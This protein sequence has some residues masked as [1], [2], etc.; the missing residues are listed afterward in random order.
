MPANPL[1]FG[2][3]G[4]GAWGRCH[5][6]AV[7]KTV[8]AELT[9]IAGRS[10]SSCSAARGAFPQARVFADYRD[11][12]AIDEIDIVDIVVPSHLHYEI[13]SAALTAGKHVLL[14]KPM[15]LS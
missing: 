14:E 4:F 11:F 12:L 6:A 7:A 2:L 9:A 3:V 1:R 8:G 5:A 13:A 15:A 10:E